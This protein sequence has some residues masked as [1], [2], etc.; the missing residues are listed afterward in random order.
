MDPMVQEITDFKPLQVYVQSS[1]GNL[2]ELAKRYYA[3][4]GARLGFESSKDFEV[5]AG[6]VELPPLDIAWLDGDSLAAGFSFCFGSKK[7]ALASLFSLF[8]AKP[9][10]SVIITSS[11]AKNFSPEEFKSLLE[12]Q[13]FLS[14]SAQFLL[15]DIAAEKFLVVG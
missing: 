10:L 13:D 9:G 12:E 2:F 15:V 7:E 14:L 5:D 1:K 8:A 6:S 11:K 3:Y 4:L